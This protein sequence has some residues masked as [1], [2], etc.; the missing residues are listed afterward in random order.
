MQTVMF[1]VGP[2]LGHV[3][4]SLTIARALRS[5]GREL[6]IVFAAVSPGNGHRLLAPEF[7]CLPLQYS[8]PGDETFADNLEST[9]TSLAPDMICLDLSPSPWLYL[10]RLPEIRRAYVTNVFLTS[11]VPTETTQV[12]HLRKRHGKWNRRRRR[13]G[14]P[15]LDDVKTLYDAD[16]ILLC[17]PIAIV[18]RG[19]TIADPYSVIGPCVWQPSEPT[20][21]VTSSAQR[22]LLVTLGSTGPKRLPRKQVA[23]LIA[24]LG[25]DSTVWVVDKLNSRPL[26]RL[27]EVHAGVPLGPILQDSILAVTH[28]G[29]GSTYAALSARVPV[30]VWPRTRNHEI[31]GDLLTGAGL[32][33]RVADIADL[34]P[35]EIRRKVENMKVEAE[36]LRVASPT[37]TGPERAAKIL[38]AAL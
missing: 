10:V 35:A 27:D 29:A 8:E 22:Q 24:S 17:D 21:P 2:A 18:P 14:L 23:R 37:A 19:V 13:R 9:V 28:G 36:R 4:R 5:S 16:E 38:L 31:L 32:G 15:E 11:L 26:R 25:C 33:A 20:P 3:G 7:E 1:V 34:G 30:A 6:N 12:L